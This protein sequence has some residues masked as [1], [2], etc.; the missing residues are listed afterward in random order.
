MALVEE[1]ENRDPKLL[2]RSI[3]SSSSIGKSSSGQCH[4]SLI[5]KSSSGRDVKHL[6]VRQLQPWSYLSV[7]L[8]KGTS[9][10]V[11]FFDCGDFE[12]CDRCHVYLI[13]FCFLRRFAFFASELG[14]K[15]DSKRIFYFFFPQETCNKCL[16][17]KM[18]HTLI[19][20]L[21]FDYVRAP[22]HA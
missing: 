19:N 1:P 20:K 16:L 21:T 12:L 10:S 6:R 15:L 4:P 11:W 14:S 5:A 9:S 8:Q 3:D 22:V 18:T 17:F 7:I 13:H 2:H